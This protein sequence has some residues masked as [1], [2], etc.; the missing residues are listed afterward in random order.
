MSLTLDQ[1]VPEGLAWRAGRVLDVASAW[2]SAIAALVLAGLMVLVVSGFVLRYAFSSSI[3]GAEAAGIWLNVAIVGLGA[4]LALNSTL[5]MR[6]DVF[7]RLLPRHV[8]LGADM[9]AEAMTLLSGLVIAHGSYTVTRIVG[10]TNAGLGLPEWIPFALFALGGGL[11]VLFTVLKLIADGRIATLVVALALAAFAFWLAGSGIRIETGLPKSL[12][13][14][15]IVVVGLVVAAPLP[16]A[17]IAGAFLVVPFGSPLPEPAILNSAVSGIMKFL[18]LAIPFFLLT[19]TLLARSGVATRLIEF[20]GALVGHMRGGLA[21][22]TLLTNVF[23]SGASGSSIASAAFG[24]ATFQPELERHGYP[25]AKAGAIIAATS[26]LDNVIPPSIAFLILAMATNLSVG[27][28][29][30]GGLWGGLVMA[31]ALFVVIRLTCRDAPVS[32]PAAGGTRWRLALRAV[33]A[34][35]LGLI[36]VFGIRLGLVTT[37]EAAA[38][39]ALY[40][41]GLSVWFGVGARGLVAA[42][43]QSATEAAAIALLIASA[44]PFAF[45]L[46]VDDI[47]GL[48]GDLAAFFGQGPVAALLVSAIILFLVGL[49]LDIGAAILLFGPLLLPIATAAGIDPIVF[50]VI[51][52]VNLMIGGLTPPF[53]VLVF[54]V[55]GVTGVPTAHLFRAVLPHVA[56][57]TVALFA[58]SLFALV[59]A[60]IA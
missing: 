7:Q 50:G 38:M 24:A 33:P 6:L 2:L 18:L 12:I 58:I 31:V 52:V 9:V 42:F 3:M 47:S 43:R 28:L 4:P 59:W 39:A 13:L 25:P 22:T 27:Q 48:I 15:L 45:L 10:G 56:G 20:A 34:F 60:A 1:G 51:M 40:T 49:V 44:A 54:V 21:Q 11:V 53:G 35:G 16:H 5:A 55:G 8:R 37:T 17:F 41:F 29:L 19:G 32:A 36:V 14:G 30:V 23:F 57:L 26:V 46:A